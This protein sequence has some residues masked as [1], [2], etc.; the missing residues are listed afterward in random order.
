MYPNPFAPRSLAAALAAA[1]A[2][3]AR[4]RRRQDAALGRPRRPADDGPA[5]AEREPHQQ[6]QQA[7][8]RVPG[9]A[10]TRTSTSSRP[11]R[12]SWT[13]GQPD[14]LALQAAA[15]RQVPRRH[16]VHRRRRRVLRSSAR[17][18][19]HLADSR[20]RQRRRHA[21]EDRRPDGRVHHQRAEP[22]HARAPRDA[23][24]SCRKAWCEKNKCEKPLNFTNKED[25]ITR[26]QRQRHRA[27]T[28]SSRAS[29]T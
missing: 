15:G 8:L 19:R 17:A 6:H 2:L 14:D 12:R 3:A 25:M 10:A 9:A 13:A 16:A 5:L 20:L 22:D 29:P 27:R 1:L 21:E 18:S 4:R 24:T 26:A 28:C 23:S 7:G 11:R